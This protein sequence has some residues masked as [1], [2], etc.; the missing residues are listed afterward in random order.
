MHKN[1]SDFM[2]AND[3]FRAIKRLSFN[4]WLNKLEAPWWMVM[5]Q[6]SQDKSL[7]V[8]F[9]IC[10]NLTVYQTQSRKHQRFIAVCI[11]LIFISYR[12]AI[13]Y[14]S[15]KCFPDSWWWQC[16]FASRIWIDKITEDK[17]GGKIEVLCYSLWKNTTMITH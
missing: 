14:I 4:G 16:C 7:K 17:M 8:K 11:H 15:I 10:D 13:L 3:I 9:I 2:A 12:A 5:L 1:L 6:D